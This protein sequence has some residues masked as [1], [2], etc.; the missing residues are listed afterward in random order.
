MQLV[1]EKKVNARLCIMSSAYTE[2]M[3]VVR[4]DVDSNRLQL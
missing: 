3:L 4:D 2:L 1:Q